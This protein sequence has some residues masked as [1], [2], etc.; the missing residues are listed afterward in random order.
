MARDIWAKY[1][2]L[3]VVE[4]DSVDVCFFRTLSSLG[5]FW[6]R[7][8][9]FGGYISCL[10]DPAQGVGAAIG[11]GSLG[12]SGLPRG[13]RRA[14]SD[15]SLL[16]AGALPRVPGARVSFGGRKFSACSIELP[17]KSGNRG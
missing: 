13:I 15:S 1:V 9:Y 10:S 3:S 6:S 4:H 14:E 17:A 5:G 16:G 11:R 8:D 7:A 2:S 12:A